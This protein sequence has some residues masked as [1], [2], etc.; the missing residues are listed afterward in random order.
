[1]T[2]WI[3]FKATKKCKKS[4]FLWIIFQSTCKIYIFNAKI[5]Y[6]M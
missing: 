1:M 6:K 5:N 4:W 2:F 3:P